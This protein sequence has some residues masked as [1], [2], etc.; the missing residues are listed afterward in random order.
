MTSSSCVSTSSISLQT[1]EHANGAAPV[2]VCVSR[3]CGHVALFRGVRCTFY[4]ASGPPPRPC[5][6]RTHWWAISWAKRS[7]PQKVFALPGTFF[8]SARIGARCK[9]WH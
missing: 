6:N 1:N 2:H 3:A 5:C 7:S 9:Y 4:V 8:K